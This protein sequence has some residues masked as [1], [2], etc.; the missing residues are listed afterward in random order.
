MFQ[1]SGGHIR[2]QGAFDLKLNFNLVA[3]EDAL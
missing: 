2:T 3:R 1:K